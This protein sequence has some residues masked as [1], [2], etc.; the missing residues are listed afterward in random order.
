MLKELYQL[1]EK[2]GSGKEND[3]YLK[4]NVDRGPSIIKVP[5]WFGK[6][7][8]T[9][10]KA[11]LEKCLN[12]LRKHEI[13]TIQTDIRE[14]IR[15][16]FPPKGE[17]KSHQTIIEP[18]IIESPFIEDIDEYKIIY[19]DV[20]D[21]QLGPI[22]REKL[23]ELIHKAD[24]IYSNDELG[25]DLLGGDAAQDLMKA[26][27]QTIKL[28]IAKY[29]PQF[30][31][32]KIENR[33]DGIRGE[34]R[35]LI[36][37]DKEIILIDPGM[38]DLSKTGKLKIITRAIH[39]ISIAL[40]IELIKITDPEYDT[41]TLPYNGSELERKFAKSSIHIA[42]PLF[43]RYIERSEELTPPL[44]FQ[45]KELIPKSPAKSADL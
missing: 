27:Y 2:V 34:I 41:S 3:C 4:Y 14:N 5:N 1:E 38:H 43:E 42:I 44:P 22:I 7:W 16:A 21:E 9:Q 6:L 36:M 30:I 33:T 11:F 40:L 25:L 8:Q 37:K 23:A 39:H 31:R 20:I 35:N 10:G 45:K 24:E 19:S 12:A 29:L 28:K 32:E 13:N 15:L 26:W 18:T 17:T